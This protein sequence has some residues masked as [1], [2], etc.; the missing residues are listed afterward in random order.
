MANGEGG[1]PLTGWMGLALSGV[2]GLLLG[3]GTAVRLAW[4]LRERISSMEASTTKIGADM[5]LATSEIKSEMQ[6]LR[7]EL[8]GLIDRRIEDDR[9]NHVWP[10][11]QAEIIKP[12]DDMGD[13][14]QK[15]G[16]SLAVLLERD[17]I[18]TAIQAAV[19]LG[20]QR[21]GSDG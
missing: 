21:G 18:S 17:R 9:H 14:Q 5:V 13:E 12:L 4:T 10:R 1:L 7:L 20:R 19:S 16:Q 3:V 15:M 6:N 2:S 8:A 11:I